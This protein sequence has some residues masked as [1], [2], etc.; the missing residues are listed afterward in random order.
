VV[1]PSS[2]STPIDV[3]SESDLAD[4]IR[5]LREAGAPDFALYKPSTL[6]RRIERRL[7][8]NGLRTAGEY[9][10]LLANHPGERRLLAQEMLVGVTSFFR[11]EPLWQRLRDELLPAL[12]VARGPRAALRAW[13]AGCSTGEEAHSRAIAHSEFTATPAHG[14]R[15]SLQI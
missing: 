6:G 12:A 7:L 14:E 8:L 2:E 9:A 3:V 10:R 4:I 15:G 5:L 1:V 11:D 13:V